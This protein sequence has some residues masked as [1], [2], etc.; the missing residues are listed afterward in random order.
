M[1]DL[2]DISHSVTAHFC[3]QGVA[4]V[5]VV[6]HMLNIGI[7]TALEA[8]M[9]ATCQPQRFNPVRFTITSTCSEAHLL[10]SH[11]ASPPQCTPLRQRP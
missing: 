11:H 7:L 3:W 5:S 10:I 6:V 2:T 1:A 8:D 4:L 9:K